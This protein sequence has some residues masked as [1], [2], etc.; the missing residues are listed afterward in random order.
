MSYFYQPFPKNWPRSQFGI[1]ATSVPPSP[2]KGADR[3][4]SKNTRAKPMVV[5]NPF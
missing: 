5:G 3:R 4:W 1:P 2:S